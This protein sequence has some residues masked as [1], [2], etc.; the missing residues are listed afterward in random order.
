MSDYRKLEDFGDF[1]Q[2][3]KTSDAGLTAKM[4][5]KKGSSVKLAFDAQENGFKGQVWDDNIEEY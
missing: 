5:V 1:E 3:E 2:W 4:G